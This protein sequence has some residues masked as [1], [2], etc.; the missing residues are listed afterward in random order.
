[1]KS[2]FPGYY[3][4]KPE[5]FAEKFKTCVFCFDTNVLFNLYHFTPESKDSL[6]NVLQHDDVRGR[7]WLP[8][9]V[10]FEYQRRRAEVL[11][12]QKGLVG[13]TEG[14][15]DTAIEQLRNLCRTT[16]FAVNA[17][18]DP[19]KHDLEEIK[20]K[21]QAQKEAK[22]DLMEGD[23]IF[24]AL[25]EVFEGKVG[26]PYTTDQ[27]KVIYKQGKER[28]EAKIPPGFE[29]RSKTRTIPINMAT[30]SSGSKSL[31]T[32]RAKTSQSFS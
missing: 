21:L 1:M 11:L 5:E 26:K 3:R 27:E 24:D 4:P 25:T 2:M 16:M 22:P 6:L 17:L 9:R 20:K 12:S 8:H 32:Q 23:D 18:I 15:I 13:K 7:I 28:Y 30:C 19:I 14:I 29:D 10:G 31:S